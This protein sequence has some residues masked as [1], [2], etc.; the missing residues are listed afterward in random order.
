ME[1]TATPAT[2]AVGGTSAL[3]ATFTDG[4]GN[5][6]SG[7]A[8]KFGYGNTTLGSERTDA[9]GTA[10]YTFAPTAEGPVS[11]WAGP[12]GSQTPSASASVAVLPAGATA[13]EAPAALWFSQAPIPATAGQAQTVT[14]HVVNAQGR[15]VAGAPV[16]FSSTGS[17]SGTWSESGSVTTN[18]D[19]TA[20]DTFTGSGTGSAWVSAAADAPGGDPA[21]AALARGSAHLW[22]LPAGAPR[23]PVPTSVRVVVTPEIV[24]SA[25]QATAT[26]VVTGPEGLPATGFAG[27]IRAA[28]GRRND[29][30]DR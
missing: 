2:I 9:G 12:K 28:L 22:M 1:L 4:D 7:A 8:V 19:G 15:P 11:L 6:I 10:R 23:G 30:D 24:T 25:Q 16:L 18:A 26:A 29:L 3:V 13:G 27:A 21:H 14:V 20:T 5:P 17:S